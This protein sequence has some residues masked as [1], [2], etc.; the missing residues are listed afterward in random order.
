MCYASHYT[1]THSYECVRVHCAYTIF[2]FT[3]RKAP[4]LSNHIF[5]LSPI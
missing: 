1:Y 5:H 4:F 2:R 3:F